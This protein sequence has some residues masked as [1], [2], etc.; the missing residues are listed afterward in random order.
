MEKALTVD[1]ATHGRRLVA[2]V[3]CVHITRAKNRTVG[4]VENSSDPDDLQAWCDECERFF[5][6]EGE[7]T[8]AFRAFNDMQVVCARC[9]AQLRERQTAKAASVAHADE[10]R[11]A[12]HLGRVLGSAGFVWHEIVSDAIH[13]DVHVVAPSPRRP[14]HV[15]VTSGMSAL[16]MN[17]P[18]RDRDRDQR[19][20]AELCVFLPPR[21]K[22]DATSL[23]DETFYWPARLL[24]RIARLPHENETWLDLGHTVANEDPPVPYAPSTK[25]AACMLVSPR[26]LGASFEKVPGEPALRILQL[27]PITAAELAFKL[28]KGDQ[29]LIERLEA[30]RGDEVYGPLDPARRS[31]VG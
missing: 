22:L 1:C 3:V 10:A 30:E 29:A 9:Y 15:L 5:T 25:L 21:W 14:F 17:I 28:E 24:K 2:S 12:T 4:F 18:K 16:P 19:L 27:L 20:Y 6:G 31:V 7:M 13:V 23:R 11:I 8:D 26:S